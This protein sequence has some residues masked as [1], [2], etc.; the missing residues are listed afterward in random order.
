MTKIK[1]YKMGVDN[2]FSGCVVITEDNKLID[3]CMYPKKLKH[4]NKLLAELKKE[5]KNENYLY[6]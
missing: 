5:K 3:I 1:K 4:N 6:F 2:A